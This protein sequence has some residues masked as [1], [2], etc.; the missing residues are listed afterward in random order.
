MNGIRSHVSAVACHPSKSLV[1]LAIGEGYLQ[2]WDYVNKKDYFNDFQKA[3]LSTKVAEKGP[4]E[5]KGK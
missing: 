2:L 1:A 5:R 4:E 3:D